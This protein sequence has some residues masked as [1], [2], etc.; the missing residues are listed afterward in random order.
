MKSAPELETAFSM[1]FAEM[2]ACEKQNTWWAL[3]HIL[4]ALPDICAALDGRSQGAQRYVDWCDENF[5]T[6]PVMMPGDR[7]QMRC[8]LL[9][10][11]TTV[12]E[13]GKKHGTQYTVFSFI[14][15]RASTTVHQLVEADTTRHGSMCTVNIKGLADDT[16]KALRNW[17]WRVAGDAKRNAI[18]EA[19][20]PGIAMVKPKEMK[21]PPTTPGG[22]PLIIRT[23]TTSSS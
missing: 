3:L 11:G 8:A 16:R 10:E 21:V 14:D 18:V 19:N 5:P 22:T 9:H 23:W 15:P 7:Y 13:Q 20:L 17:F 12:P 6:D 1:Y 4:V 2:D